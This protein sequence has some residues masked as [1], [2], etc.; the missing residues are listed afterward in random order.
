MS[1]KKIASMSFVVGSAC[2][3]AR[4]GWHMA[5]EIDT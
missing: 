1:E 4:S 3:G 2:G 5:L